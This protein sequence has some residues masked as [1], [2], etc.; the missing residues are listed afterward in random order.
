MPGWGSLM[1]HAYQFVDIDVVAV[2]VV[3]VIVIANTVVAVVDVVVVGRLGVIFAH[4]VR[5][6]S[7]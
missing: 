5:P 4:I 2:V 6:R 1:V 3:V 7:A